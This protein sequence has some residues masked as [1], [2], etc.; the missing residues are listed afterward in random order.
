VKAQVNSQVLLTKNISMPQSLSSILIHLVFSTK[1][2][3][4]FITPAVETELH[5]YLATIFRNNYSPSLIIDG[6]PDH[7][8]ALFALGRTVTVADVVEEV[9]T[10]S[11]KWLKT[12][13]REFSN[14]H[15]QRGYGAFSIGQSNVADLK[16][17]I[18]NQKV[19]HR[20]VTFQDEY[21]E[22]LK[23]YNV[24]FDERYVWD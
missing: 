23:A 4:P 14:F 8:H 12:K 22:F 1:N 19:H 5:P 6:T 17:Y 11:S 24:D 18:G 10:G 9:K 2:R 13:G 7:I 15:W 20:R 21:R 16:R 3:Q